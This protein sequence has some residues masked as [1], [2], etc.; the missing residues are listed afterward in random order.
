MRAAEEALRRHS[1]AIVAMRLFMGFFMFTFVG[2]FVD[3][4]PWPGAKAVSAKAVSAKPCRKPTSSVDDEMMPR[5]RAQAHGMHVSSDCDKDLAA[6]SR[7]ASEHAYVRVFMMS[8]C[9]FAARALQSLVPVMINQLAR[10]GAATTL[11]LEF[12][13]TGADERSFRSLHG[14]SEVTG[15]RL[16]L[17]LQDMTDQS[18]FLRAVHCLS[19]NP[20]RVGSLAWAETCFA[21]AAIAQAKQDEIMDCADDGKTPSLDMLA[22]TFAIATEMRLG[23][24][25]TI[26]FG[27]ETAL[28]N[29]TTPA[30]ASQLA[31]RGLTPGTDVLYCG[32]RVG[33]DF[34]DA[35]CETVDTFQRGAALGAHLHIGENECPL[36]SPTESEPEC[37]DG[38]YSSNPTATWFPGTFL[39]R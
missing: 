21:H 19:S 24:S 18:T 16:Y 33:Q 2:L 25:P 15:D 5:R 29:A 13:G 12:I 9:P 34:V 4:V 39:R 35:T 32:D 27:L 23:E 11:K 3:S 37:V 31:A 17:C 10:G 7:S 8:H 36:N 22:D 30:I 20:S 14:P 38:E 28:G 26:F 1:A 6:L